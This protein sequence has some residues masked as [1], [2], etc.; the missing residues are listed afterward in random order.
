MT[1]LEFSNKRR[2]ALMT[3]QSSPSSWAANLGAT[4]SAF[5]KALIDV[6]DN[7]IDGRGVGSRFKD[8]SPLEKTK[9]LLFGEK[10]TKGPHAGKRLHPVQGPLNQSGRLVSKEVGESILSGNVPGSVTKGTVGGKTVYYAKKF[11]PG[12]L[13]GVAMRNPGKAGIAALAAYLLLKPEGR[14][15]AGGIASS[16]KPNIPTAPTADVAREWGQKQ[17]TARPVLQQQAWG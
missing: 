16:L 10:A 17:Q 13:A 5:G 15:A 8:V 11:R 4:G 6:I 7:P 1:D 12:G 3:K 14:Q 9:Q 2:I